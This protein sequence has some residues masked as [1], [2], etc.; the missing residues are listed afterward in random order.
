[1]FIIYCRMFRKFVKNTGCVRRAP[2]MHCL[3]PKT[4]TCKVLQPIHPLD[5][6][7]R[8]WQN[9]NTINTQMSLYHI[10]CLLSS[11]LCNNKPRGF[12]ATS[13]MNW[14]VTAS[15]LL[16]YLTMKPF[17]LLLLCTKYCHNEH[18]CLR[19]ARSLSPFH[20]CRRD[21]NKWNWFHAGSTVRILHG[22]N[23]NPE[24]GR[25]FS[26]EST[27]VQVWEAEFK[28]PTFK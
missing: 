3:T 5:G 1:M 8:G 21:T 23:P 6:I 19:G 24:L 11:V 18:F 16:Y 7:S 14:Q 20:P 12:V 2:C 25:Q 17:L 9:G 10:N 27:F 15:M 28:S 26:G 4:V 22:K 13:E